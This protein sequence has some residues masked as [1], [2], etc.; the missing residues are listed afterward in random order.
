MS[1]ADKRESQ[2]HTSTFFIYV[3]SSFKLELKMFY[4]TYAARKLPKVPVTV[5][6]RHPVTPGGHGMVPSAAERQNVLCSVRRTRYNALSIG[7]TQQYFCFSPWWPWPLTFDLWP[8]HSNSSERGI[9]H[10]FAV[11]LAQIRP[12]VPDIF[13]WQP[14]N[15]DSAKNGTLLVCGNCIHSDVSQTFIAFLKRLLLSFTSIFDSLSYMH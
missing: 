12:A 2:Q 3:K 11:N 8:W 15:T 5:H 6:C 10:V 13:E 14:K 1:K 7:M 4:Q 9:K